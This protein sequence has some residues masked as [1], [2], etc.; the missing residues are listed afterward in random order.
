[1]GGN[2]PTGERFSRSYVI[3][4]VLAV[5]SCFFI[6]ASFIVK[7][8]GLRRLSSLG[9]RRAGSGGYGYLRQWIW[10][11]GLISSEFTPTDSAPRLQPGR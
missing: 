11:C 2:A 5:S 10:W 8:I 7:K 1:M 4:L 9:Q 3:G 6:G